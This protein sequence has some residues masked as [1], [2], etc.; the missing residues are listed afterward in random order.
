MPYEF[1]VKVSVATTMKH[2]KGGQFA[3]HAMA[4]PG[5]PYDGHTLKQVIP[6]MQ[7]MIGNDIKRILADAGYR[8]HHAPETH[9]FR[10]FTQGQKRGVSDGVK[11]MMK[12]RAAIEPVI[13]H[14]KNEHRMNRNYLAHTTGDAINAILAAAGYNFRLLLNWLKD[15]LLFCAMAL[16]AVKTISQT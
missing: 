9:K 4:L 11:K 7:S 5:N 1:G 13:G 6:D 14:I 10:V 2:A 8:G 3:L 16:F 12:R 15:F